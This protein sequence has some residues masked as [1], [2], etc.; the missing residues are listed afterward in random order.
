MNK[1]LRLCLA[2]DHIMFL[3]Y[4]EKEDLMNKGLRLDNFV[5]ES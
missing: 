4:C 1:G 3:L 2:C 5:T